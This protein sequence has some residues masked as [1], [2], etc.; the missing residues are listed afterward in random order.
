MITGMCPLSFQHRQYY[1][2]SDLRSFMV[3]SAPSLEIIYTS[4]F[5]TESFTQIDTHSLTTG[6]LSTAFGGM[7]VRRLGIW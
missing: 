1:K 6:P 2:S 5:T 7:Y 4:L 3:F